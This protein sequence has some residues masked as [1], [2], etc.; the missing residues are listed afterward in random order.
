MPATWRI[1][2]QSAFTDLRRHGRRSRS[3]PVSVTWSPSGPDGP[4]RVGYA[5]GKGVGNAVTRNKVRR[6]LQAVV[7]GLGPDLG[8]GTYLV[9]AGP[10]VATA[11]FEQLATHLTAALTALPAPCGLA[12]T[13]H[14][15][16]SGAA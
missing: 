15:L 9:G 16:V 5:V 4:P 12:A 8:P 11:T 14:G 6:R 10:A 1:R 2:E 3:G 13:S 7:A